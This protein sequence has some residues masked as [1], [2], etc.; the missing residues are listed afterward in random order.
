MDFEQTEPL[1]DDTQARLNSYQPQ[2]DRITRIFVAVILVVAGV[3]ALTLLSPVIQLLTLTFIITFMM[4]MPSAWLAKRLRLP[5]TAAVASVYGGFVLLVVVLL[6][7]I[8]PTLVAGL[9]NLVVEA[10]FRYEELIEQAERYRYEQGIVEVGGVEFDLNFIVQPLRDFV[11]ASADASDSAPEN[12]GSTVEMLEQFDEVARQQTLRD[13][14]NIIGQ[15]TGVLAST[16]TGVLGFVITLLLSVFLSLLILIDLPRTRAA[17]MRMVPRDYHREYTLLMERIYRVWIG[18]MRGE[19]AIGLLIGV[20]TWLQLRVMG[21]ESAGT[22]A[23]LVGFISLIP[24]LGGFLALIP[25]TIVPLLSGSTVFVDWPPGTVAL[26]VVTVNL[27]VSQLIWNVIAP[28]ILGEAVNLPLP[29]IIIGVFIGGALGG[30][31]GAFLVVPIMGTLSVLLAYVLSKLTLRDPYPEMANVERKR[32]LF[33]F[34]RVLAQR[35]RSAQA[36]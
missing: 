3:Y 25:L 5:W 26:A 29:V 34:G 16:V 36:D 24:T 14:A 28:S 27:I 13:F 12:A 20:V 4:Y 7:T 32:S 6:L 30:I 33:E 10:G 22:L 18:F 21:I 2:W 23:L 15:I 8:V 35:N 9:N 19:L 11:L 1:P 17:A 31:L